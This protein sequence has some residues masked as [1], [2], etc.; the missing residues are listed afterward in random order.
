MISD[1]KVALSW[2]RNPNLRTQPFVQARVHNICKVFDGTEAFYIKSSE[3]PS[4]LGT[5][6]NKFT[7]T[8]LLLGE[9]HQQPKTG[10]NIFSVGSLSQVSDNIF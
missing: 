7:D 10:T 5:K 9:S 3:N 2:I 8:F 6:F 4:D 1:S